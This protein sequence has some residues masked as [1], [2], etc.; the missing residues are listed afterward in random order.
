[1]FEDAIGGNVV[2]LGCSVAVFVSANFV[3][4]LKT[5]PLFWIGQELV[6]RI[7]R[8]DSPILSDQQVRE[9]NSRGGLNLVV[10]QSGVRPDYLR[11][12]EVGNAVITSFIE[13]YRG[14][15]LEEII[16]QAESVEHLYGMRN[17]GALYFDPQDGRYKG[18]PELGVDEVATKPHMI[19]LTRHDAANFLGSWVGSLFLYQCPR[20]GFS[21]S[22][23]HLLSSAL[24]G[25]TDE[26][27]SHQLKVSL[28]AI[29]KTW[30]GIYDRATMAIPECIF[31]EVSGA[32]Q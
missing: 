17:V 24:R 3:T 26:D 25:G 20:C 1:M 2:P 30:R 28:S 23:Q 21:R 13:L 31:D 19:G 7:L 32:V 4:E 27:L 15:L 8:G 18:L 6:R 5:P 10:W 11:L 29:K 12:S 9:A 14:Y 16:A 22:E